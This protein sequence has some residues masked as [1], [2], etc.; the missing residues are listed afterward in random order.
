MESLIHVLNVMPD[1]MSA[2]HDLKI[3]Y[4]T[5]SWMAGASP[6]MTW[7]DLANASV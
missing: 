2:I 6:A 4:K 5:K 1:F 7:V 3:T